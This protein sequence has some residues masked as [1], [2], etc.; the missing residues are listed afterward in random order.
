MHLISIGGGG[1]ER[2]WVIGMR[3]GLA[4]SSPAGLMSTTVRAGI[5]IRHQ[6][7]D[8]PE[9]LIGDHKE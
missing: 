7:I 5:V 3:D 4:F 6:R 8:D 9:L 2:G 1:V